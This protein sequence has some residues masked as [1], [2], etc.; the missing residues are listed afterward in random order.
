[1]QVWALKSESRAAMTQGHPPDQADRQVIGCIQP[2]MPPG[3]SGSAEPHH[4]REAAGLVC[5]PDHPRGTASRVD[6]VRLRHPGAPEGRAPVAGVDGRRGIRARGGARDGAVPAADRRGAGPP[7]RF[8]SHR[9]TNPGAPGKGVRAV[10]W[11]HSPR[12]VAYPRDQVGS[13]WLSADEPQNEGACAISVLVER[14]VATDCP[15]FSRPT[16]DCQYLVGGRRVHEGER[17]RPAILELH[18]TTAVGETRFVDEDTAS[19]LVAH[20]LPAL[21]ELVMEDDHVRC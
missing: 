7:S 2:A 1:M 20:R 3:R 13:V 14:A 16:G 10:W 4:R 11:S 15:E 18:D 8:L 19:D 17:D 5:R 6:D 21:K 9:E 12:W